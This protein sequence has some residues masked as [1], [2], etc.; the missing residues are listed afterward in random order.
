MIIGLDA[1]LVNRQVPACLRWRS[2]SLRRW[3]RERSTS[4][5]ASF[6]SPMTRPSGE[7][8]MC[9]QLDLT[10]PFRGEADLPSIPEAY[11]GAVDD[12]VAGLQ[13]GQN[14]Q[15][16]TVHQ[17]I[18][19]VRSNRPA[20]VS[21]L[22]HEAPL[23]GGVEGPSRKVRLTLQPAY[24]DLS[25][26]RCKRSEPRRY[27]GIRQLHQDFHRGSM[28]RLTGQRGDRPHL[29]R[30]SCPFHVQGGRLPGLHLIDLPCRDLQ[31]S[32]LAREVSHP[33]QLGSFSDESTYRPV[34]LENSP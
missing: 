3:C 12:P 19:H 25:G 8:R 9:L 23:T 15:G 20:I 16:S 27:I 21:H 5:G 29:P 4:Q 13:A 26:N 32:H 17:A 14:L 33:E 22:V 24:L 34:P 1:A 18:A 6:R 28:V 7:V 31:A 30:P 11:V 10:H 2:A